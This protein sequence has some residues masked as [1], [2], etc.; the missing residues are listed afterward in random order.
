MEDQGLPIAISF[1]LSPRQLWNPGLADDVAGS[2]RAEGVDP[3][4]LIVEITESAAMADP[5]R[6]ELALEALSDQGITIAIDDFGTS[7]LIAEPSQAAPREHLED[8]P[9]V[10]LGH[11]SGCGG[12]SVDDRDRAAGT[13]PGTHAGGRRGRIRVTAPVP[14]SKK[15]A[16]WPKETFWVARPR[17]PSCSPERL[18]IREAGVQVSTLSS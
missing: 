18:L 12:L 13:E 4:R 5:I 2:L 15:G 7:G 1:N 11:S 6:T 17:P 9:L 8:G 10:S 16:R 14:R 3:R